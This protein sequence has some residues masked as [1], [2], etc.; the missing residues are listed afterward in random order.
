MS[1]RKGS[2][3]KEKLPAPLSMTEQERIELLARLFLDIFE[4]EKKAKL[5]S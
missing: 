3:N 2:T 1:R 5:V 4:E